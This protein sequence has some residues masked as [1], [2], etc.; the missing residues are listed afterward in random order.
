MQGAL[1]IALTITLGT[2]TGVPKSKE[3]TKRVNAAKRAFQRADYAESARL[4][5]DAYEFA[6]THKLPD[7]P[8]LLFNAGLAYERLGACD[9]VVD[10]FGRYFELRPSAR[11]PDLDF[12]FKKA[13]DCAPQIRFESRPAG[14]RVA[15]DD[16]ILGSTPWAAH[17]RAGPRRV[18]W[19]LASGEVYEE[20]VEITASAPKTI[21]RALDVGLIEISGAAPDTALTID[22]VRDP[23]PAGE[24]L[25]LPPGPHHIQ[26]S[27]AGCE[28]REVKVLVE[29]AR[30]IV[31][32]A[33][34]LTCAPPKLAAQTASPELTARAEL[35]EGGSN[36]PAW[37][38]VGAGG[39]FAAGGAVLAV[40]SKNA[41]GAQNAELTRPSAERDSALI[42][43]ER[44]DAVNFAIGAHVAFGTAIA[45]A[46]AGAVLFLLED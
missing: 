16:R 29:R 34:G 27:R 4:Y 18:R 21:T 19:T 12:R 13:V 28:T 20:I 30:K 8:E 17:V 36:T 32:V 38:A 1:L 23:R 2:V 22:G 40:L 6:K 46:A 42:R 11:N 3:A 45:S 33:G 37:I 25:E 5:Q 10:F 31:P 41:V 14:A 44:K 9:R 39:V 43:G 24:R 7:K 35:D 15:V 26:L